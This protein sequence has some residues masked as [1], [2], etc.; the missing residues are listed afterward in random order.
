MKRST[1]AT[2]NSLPFGALRVPKPVAGEPCDLAECIARLNAAIVETM[3]AEDPDTRAGIFFRRLG[4]GLCADRAY[5]FELNARGTYDNTY[6][7]CAPGVA[8]FRAQLQDVSESAYE[9]DLW[10]AL[11]AKECFAVS[12]MEA[13]R[14]HDTRMADL[15]AE[16]DV[17]FFVAAPV[18]SSGELI[19][20][21]GLDNPVH[22]EIDDV[23]ALM[24]QIAL[25]VA[26][27]LDRREEWSSSCAVSRFDP[28]TGLLNTMGLAY[29]VDAAIRAAR[30]GSAVRPLAVVFFDIADFKAFNRSFGYGAG[31]KLLAHLGGLLKEAVGEA[32]ACRADADHFYALVDDARAEGLI[33]AVHAKM[34]DDPTYATN[35]TG[36]IYTIDGTETSTVQALDRAKIAGGAVL[37]DFMNCWRRYS[38]DMEV[39]LTIESYVSTHVVEAVDEGWIKVYFQPVL[40]TFSGKVEGFEALARWDD[41]TYGMLTPA[42]FID[43]LE[44]TRQ[45]HLVDLCILDEVCAVIERKMRDLAPFVP[46]SVNLSRFDLE[47]PDIHDRIDAVLEAHRVPRSAVH[48]E[49]TES[50]LVDREQLIADHIAA[51]HE[52]GYE[53]WLDDFG[54]GYSSLNTLQRFDFDCVKLD[55]LFLRQETEKSR[56]LVGDLIDMAKHLGLKTLTEGVETEEQF[57]FLKGLGCSLIQ[58]YWCARPEPL[59]A[60]E[61]IL[62]ERGLAYLGAP[63]RRF[64]DDIGRVDVRGGHVPQIFEGGPSDVR[65]EAVVV[66]AEHEADVSVVYANRAFTSYLASFHVDSTS[67]VARLWNGDTSLS[68]RLRNCLHAL[69]D[70][71]Q[72]RSFVFSKG[73]NEASVRL[74]LVSDRSWG[75][76][77]LAEARPIARENVPS[78]DNLFSMVSPLVAEISVVN[79]ETDTLTIWYSVHG[80][81]QRERAS[82]CY[83]EELRRL[84]ADRVYPMDADRFF[85]FA[86]PSTMAARVDAAS[87]GILNGFFRFRV[88]D[89]AYELRRVVLSRMASIASAGSFL[90]CIMSDA[91]GLTQN[92]LEKMRVDDDG[93]SKGLS[94]E[95]LWNASL[96][97]AVSGVFWKDADRRFLGANSTFLHYY[98]L[99]MSDIIGKNDED[100]G[101]HPDPEP[102]KRDELR[103]LKH[104]AVTSDVLGTCLVHGHVHS[105]V[106]TKM[107][108]YRGERIV[109]LL[110]RFFDVSNMIETL[111]AIDLEALEPLRDQTYTDAI[112]GLP[113]A[114]GLHRCCQ[115]YERAYARAGEDFGF[116]TVQLLGTRNF[117]LDF[118]ATALDDLLRTV[119]KELAAAVPGETVGVGYPTRFGIVVRSC[120]AARLDEVRKAAEKGI[121]QVI[122]VDGEPVTVYARVGAALYSDSGD[123]GEMVAEAESRFAPPASVTTPEPA[124]APESAP[125]LP[126]GP[127]RAAS[128]VDLRARNERL[129]RENETLMRESRI[130][131]LTHALNRRG[132]DEMAARLFAQ[133]AERAQVWAVDVDNF[134]LFNDRFGHAVGDALLELLASDLQKL[135]GKEYVC[136]FGGDEFQAIV[137]EPDDNAF[138]AISSFFS[139]EHSFEAEGTRYTFRCCAGFARRSD[140][141]EPFPE[142]CR[143]ADTALYH[144]KLERG[145]V[146][147]YDAHME[148]DVRSLIGFSLADIADGIPAAV[149]AY[150][151]DPTE[152]IV[153]ANGLCADLFGCA[154]VEEFLSYTGGSFRGVVV[155][156]ELERVEAS[157]RAQ[158][159]DGTGD[160]RDFVA[161]HIVRKDGRRLR[162]LDAGRLVN[163]EYY[164]SMFFVLLINAELVEGWEA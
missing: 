124:S 1:A 159:E 112:T 139:G 140:K 34:K 21:V 88:A 11:R 10:D 45:A 145:G 107:P 68:W 164:G 58:G 9:S 151:D 54:S 123:V 53:V 87:K 105:I 146:F 122:E 135:F 108:V 143:K 38:S 155:P 52:R 130:D 30:E 3:C 149:F 67:E 6:E 127:A 119:G 72:A 104:G 101:W 161:Y 95:E 39:R 12:D 2:N 96:S 118:G 4:E 17:R 61:A 138:A 40:G 23:V 33:D 120:D 76:A 144:A 129:R 99:E 121:A 71:G 32:R 84:V 150:K 102:F 77:Y 115:R 156:S 73:T 22:L 29:A 117:R 63:E 98:G 42:I 93:L 19:G 157:I 137:P 13:Y 5:L 134:K 16:K 163:N 94:A 97:S 49:I 160:R 59:P 80:V 100:M 111:N 20:Y 37:K 148:R 31:D 65:D 91:S 90:F 106:A 47:L 162:V 109:G 24:R 141:R 60:V 86:D 70:V 83:R 147:E 78:F 46:V 55:M 27:E 110:G 50:A 56:V 85:S 131:A 116:V 26:A 103:V 136:R 154:T 7:W 153:F 132:F 126:A 74:Q 79:P 64:F 44:R 114:A 66:L 41:P 15:F 43:V 75:R 8:S 57:I 142:L 62:S 152:E 14:E 81:S 89:S 36:G 69:K 35:V 133:G 158:I 18:V 51:F 25:F 28:V 113:N 125:A 92:L 48:F 128:E 82:V